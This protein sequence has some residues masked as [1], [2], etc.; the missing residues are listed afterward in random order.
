MQSLP[1]SP[2]P[3]TMTCL[4][5]AVICGLVALRLARDAPVLL[6]QEVHGEDEAVEVAPRRGGEEIE[7]LLGAARQQQRIVPALQLLGR[8]ALADVRVAMEDDAFRLHLLHAP[9]DDLL[10]HLEV[11]DAIGQQ[12]AGLGGF[13]VDVHLVAGARQL[14][15]GGEARGPR[16]DDRHP[17]SRLALRRLGRH[18][19]LGEGPV[20]DGTLDGLDGDRVVVDVERAGGLA[21]RRA[22]APRDLGEVVGRVQV[23]RRRL[24]LVAVDEVVPVRDLVVHR[25]AAVAV[26]D[27]AVHAAR[28]LRLGLL[29]RQRHDELVPMLH[30]LVHGPVVPVA[31]VEFHEAGDLAHRLA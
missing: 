15:G 21:R 7:R 4:P 19:A 31:A 1:V 20:G 18:P 8:D 27:A 16:A 23:E 6:R 9:L 13:L 2:P 10:L 5:S 28:G 12:A 29:L 11:G 25:T 22:H 26:G 17:L 30:A 14:L 24:P 3:M